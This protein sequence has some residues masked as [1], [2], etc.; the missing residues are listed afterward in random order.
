M[1]ETNEVSLLGWITN[2]EAAH[3]IGCAAQTLRKSRTTGILFGFPAPPYIKRG[4]RVFY[5]MPTLQKFNDQFYEQKNTAQ[6]SQV[7]S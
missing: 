7:A 4:Y 6:T 1:N 2:K 3:M 5:K